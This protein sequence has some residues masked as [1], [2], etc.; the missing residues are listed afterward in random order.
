M[1]APSGTTVQ[2]S[3]GDTRTTD[4]SWLTHDTCSYVGVW[5]REFLRT[6]FRVRIQKIE[7]ELLGID[8]AI[9]V[10]FFGV[11]EVASDVFVQRP[12]T[13]YEAYTEQSATAPMLTKHF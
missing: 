10:F 5:W 2:Q 7:K 9:T 11:E 12:S 8:A 6:P 3:Q 1:T 13:V 4:L